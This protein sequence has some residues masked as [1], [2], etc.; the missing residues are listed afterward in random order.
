MIWPCGSLADVTR[1]FWFPSDGYYL[2]KH[3]AVDLGKR[4]TWGTR[5]ASCLPGK[6]SYKAYDP[7]YSGH[8]IYVDT[9]MGDGIVIRCCYRH[10]LESSPLKVGAPV[11]QGQIIGRVGATGDAQG[12]HLHFD[13][14]VN[15]PIRDDSIIW[16]ARVGRYAVDPLIYLGQEVCVTK[17]EVEKIVRDTTLTH[18]ARVK[19]IPGWIDALLANVGTLNEHTKHPP[20]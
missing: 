17:A 1:G 8:Y 5:I 19:T 11:A 9:P 13:M 6:V 10:L 7:V 18:D 12:P 4:V 15:K 16:K 14:W 2:K 20:A 3:Y